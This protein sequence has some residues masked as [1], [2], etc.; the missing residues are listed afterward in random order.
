M[1][2]DRKASPLYLSARSNALHFYDPSPQRRH[3]LTPDHYEH[4]GLPSSGYP[5]RNGP[6]ADR[7]AFFELFV[8]EASLAA[9]LSNIDAVSTPAKPPHSPSRSPADS[10]TTSA[11]IAPS[12]ERPRALSYTSLLD[13]VPG[14][15]SSASSAPSRGPGSNGTAAAAGS[16]QITD[17]GGIDAVDDI[18]DVLAELSLSSSSESSSDSESEPDVFGR[19]ID[20]RDDSSSAS[21]VGPRKPTAAAT[22]RSPTESVLPPPLSLDSYVD[23]APAP[24]HRQLTSSAASIRSYRSQTSG[25]SWSRR[26]QR[27]P[28]LDTLPLEVID[29]ICSYLP[30]SSLV[31][32]VR[33]CKTIACSAY[34]FLYQSPEFTSTYRF[35]Q[36]VS[37]ITHDRT[38]ASYVRK[39]DLSGMQAGL[40]GNLVLAGWRDWKYRNEPLYWTRKHHQHRHRAHSSVAAPSSPSVPIATIPSVP[41]TSSFSSSLTSSSSSS[42]KLTRPS[43]RRASLSF[44]STPTTSSNATHKSHNSHHSYHRHN[45]HSSS[46]QHSFSHSKPTVSEIT[47]LRSS[48]AAP[49]LSSR[50]TPGSAQSAAHVDS[51]HPLQSPLLRQYSLSRDVPLG[52]VIHVLRACPKIEHIDLSSLPLAADYYV[53]SRKHKPT[54]FTNLLFVSDVPKTYTWHENELVQVLAGREL[55]SAITEMRGLKSLKMRNLVWVSRETIKHIV[56]HERLRMTLEYVDFQECG[57]SRGKPWALAGALDIFNSGVLEEQA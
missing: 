15:R 1:R 8:S 33:S 23:A 3:L 56:E 50:R 49:P 20:P 12:R 28:T 45:P 5:R 34:V 46:R 17:D 39:L 43:I 21:A 41:S 7:A 54:A 27:K 36:F 25:L 40:K 48:D 22:A 6:F 53:V 32:A 57:M 13:P 4:P 9:E 29:I 26:P 19:R 42:N 10:T 14:S 52:A 55:V 18:D 37:V 51:G 38:L 11:A 44:G 2:S 30:Q 31:Q 24:A 35:A 47:P 16:A